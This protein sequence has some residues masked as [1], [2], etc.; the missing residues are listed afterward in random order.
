MHVSLNLDETAVQKYKTDLVS[1]LQRSFFKPGV[2]TISGKEILELSPYKQINL[3][4]VRQ[5]FSKWQTEMTRLKSPYFD[6][7]HTEVKSALKSFMD[8]VSRHIAVE[9]KH[10]EP[11][12]TDAIEQTIML[13]A[14]PYLF[15]SKEMERI[16]S[17]KVTTTKLLE[18]S[19]Y[20]IIN[21]EPLEY[22][23]QHLESRKIP[24]SYAGDL[25]RLFYQGVFDNGSKCTDIQIMLDALQKV[26]P[27]TKAQ[28]LADK[29]KVEANVT[30]SAIEVEDKAETGS[31]FETVLSQEPK[32]VPVVS[33]PTYT[34]Q[35]QT[36]EQ[37]SAETISGE[38]SSLENLV[39]EEPQEAP[40]VAAKGETHVQEAV[41][42]PPKATAGIN[43]PKTAKLV[44]QFVSK[45]QETTL[46]DSLTSTAVPIFAETVQTSELSSL[47]FHNKFKYIKE[48]F[49]NDV[50]AYQKAL[51]QL[52]TIPSRH[53]AIEY[54]LH[55]LAPKHHWDM[56]NPDTLSFMELVEK[57]YNAKVQ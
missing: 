17:P 23:T 14:N 8:L 39:E 22:V 54:M 15:Y 35:V 56:A 1:A 33:E 29:P 27:M 51:K 43:I 18:L 7:E 50:D 52:D 38:D 44:D 37:A 11:L 5:L 25:S 36:I 16:S 55:E 30:P 3:L 6:F 28:L 13:H 4:I 48:L 57:S 26:V 31:F 2:R 9:E 40:I 41:I 46:K 34:Y 45:K 49:G 19:K 24:E 32:F 20:I 42:V 53:E 21:R 12:L 47:I 10:L